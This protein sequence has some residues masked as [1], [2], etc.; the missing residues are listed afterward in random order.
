V[1]IKQINKKG[2]HLIT[3]CNI[4]LFFKKARVDY[5]LVMGYFK[6]SSKQLFIIVVVT[7]EASH[8]QT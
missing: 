2:K 4:L 8:S 1:L 7:S 6:S 5:S 3:K